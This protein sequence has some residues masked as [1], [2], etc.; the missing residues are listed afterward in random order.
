MK[1]K[2]LKISSD[3][4]ATMFETGKRA[5]EITKDGIPRDAFIADARLE[6]ARSFDGFNV[7]PVALFVIES[8]EF[9]ELAEGEKIPD[10]C[11]MI[12]DNTNYLIGLLN[13]AWAC[14][15]PKP[16][17][18][19]FNARLSAKSHAEIEALEAHNPLLGIGND[20][21][22]ALT[23]L[24]IIATITDVLCGKRLAANVDD[25]GI[26]TGWQ[27]YKP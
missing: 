15:D 14:L 12:T 1:R 20:R 27:W 2:I 9:P 21:E 16:R 26:I 5:Y 7:P 11:P 8:N 22:S 18:V 19:D 13:S 4:L 17:Y 25:N 24:S 23:T 10:M 6:L 3:M